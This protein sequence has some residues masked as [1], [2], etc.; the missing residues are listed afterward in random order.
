M[1]YSSDK[2][3]NGVAIMTEIENGHGKNVHFLISD[4]LKESLGNSYPT[5]SFY[6]IV[7]DTYNNI[8]AQLIQNTSSDYA[9]F[10]FNLLSLPSY[11]TLPYR[12]G[13]DHPLAYLADRYLTALSSAVRELGLSLFFRIK[14]LCPEGMSLSDITYLDRTNIA[15]LFKP[16]KTDTFL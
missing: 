15:L 5:I 6:E 16:V 11:S 14:T 1:F 12:Y 9:D 13:N 4:I 3:I 8:V 10:C 2:I 7:N